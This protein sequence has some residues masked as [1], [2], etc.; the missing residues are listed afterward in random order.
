MQL[1]DN[2]ESEGEKKN[3]NTDKIAFKGIVLP[4]MKILWSLTHPRVVPNLYVFLCSAE[5]KGRYFEESL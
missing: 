4:K 3:L 5:H 2:L 1:F